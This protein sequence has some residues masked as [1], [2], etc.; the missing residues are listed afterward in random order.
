MAN[1]AIYNGG[2]L[3]AAFGRFSL[4]KIKEEGN[5]ADFPRR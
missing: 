1:M 5:P 4:V 2:S 3:G